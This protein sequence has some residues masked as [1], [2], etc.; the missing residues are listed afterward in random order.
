LIVLCCCST[1]FFNKYLETT[2]QDT[3]FTLEIDNFVLADFDGNRVINKDDLLVYEHNPSTDLRTYI[4]H[5][6][7]KIFLDNLDSSKYRT[8]F[9]LEGCSNYAFN[10]VIK[11]KDDEFRNRLEAAMRNA[12][13]EFRRG[14]AGG[15][16]QM[17][18]PYLRERF[19]FNEETFKQFPEIEHIH[20]YAYYV[21]N[22]PG[23][24]YKKIIQLCDLL[25]SVK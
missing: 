13:I 5:K 22:Y 12:N 1:I 19:G 7:V 10:L 25:N 14:S 24:E 3:T 23:L 8:D 16:N 6:I 20:F 2:Y 18:Q 9:D 15:G 11:K 21:G 4:N 17:R